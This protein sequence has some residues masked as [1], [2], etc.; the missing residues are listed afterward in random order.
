MRYSLPISLNR[1]RIIPSRALAVPPSEVRGPRGATSL[2]LILLA[3]S[4]TSHAQNKKKPQAFGNVVSRQQNKFLDKQV[5]M[6]FKAGINLTQANV[7]K[8]YAILMPTNYDASLTKKK[9][10]N[11]NKI[12]TQ[13]TLEFTFNYKQFGFSF[14]PTYRTSRF[15]YNNQFEWINTELPTERL[16]LQYNQEQRL[17]FADLP[18]I[19]KYEFGLDK[20]KPYAQVGVFY[21]MLL[22]ATKT[23][24]VTG[25]DFASGGTNQ[26]TNEP[27]IVGAKDLFNNNWGLIGGAGVNYNVGNVRFLFDISYRLGM[28]NVANINNR[29]SNDRL[30]GIGDVQDDMRL[31]NLTFSVGCLFP[32]RFL[33]SSFKSM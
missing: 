26:F 15:T 18:F 21:S 3:I 5:W 22:N 4:L 25:T 19:I 23:V 7:E 20:V 32:M 12:G 16:V 29:F 9:Y 33:S 27:V 6:G 10:D 2:L 17:D 30:N 8:Q 28:S 1:L 14:Q 24:E 11:F 31:R 13:A